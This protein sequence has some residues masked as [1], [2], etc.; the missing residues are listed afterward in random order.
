MLALS[1][2]LGA[3][4]FAILA[5]AAF[6]VVAPFMLFVAAAALV[7]RWW[8]GMACCFPRSPSW[9]HV[10]RSAGHR[11]VRLR[12]LC[13]RRGDADRTDLAI[14]QRVASGLVFV[15]GAMLSLH[16]GWLTWRRAPRKGA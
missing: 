13:G 4:G 10:R 14:E 3:L 2:L 7:W 8:R 9:C 11:T 6:S 5:C 15:L 12:R 16:V 1:G